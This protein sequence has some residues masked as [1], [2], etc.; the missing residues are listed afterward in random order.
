M[1]LG[2]AGDSHLHSFWLLLGTARCGG[3]GWNV[4]RLGVAVVCPLGE[5]GDTFVAG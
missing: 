3:E 5:C 2:V 4:M 1:G